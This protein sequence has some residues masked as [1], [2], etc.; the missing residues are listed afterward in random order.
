MIRALCVKAVVATLVA[1]ELF[2]FGWPRSFGLILATLLAA[3]LFFTWAIAFPSSQF[4]VASMNRLPP[5]SS[6]GRSAIAFT[7]D[8]GPDP[9]YTPQ[10]LDLLEKHGAKATFFVVGERVEAHPELVREIVERGHAIGSHS[11]SH[12]L[13]FHAMGVANAKREVLRG[14]EAITKVLGKAPRLFRPPQGVRTPFLRDALA[15]IRAQVGE[16]HEPVTCVTWTARGLDATGRSAAEIIARLTPRLTPGAIV[17]LHDGGGFHGTTDR[18][19]TLAALERLLT[20][21][22][23][24]GLACVALEAA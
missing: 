4:L 8:D 1:L 11:Y 22:S 18:A 9:M 20:T 5:R 21:A 3:V 16:Q 24:R 14:I 15:Q 17:V 13:T 19:P 7:F 10:V 2:A 6:N 12:R 23:D